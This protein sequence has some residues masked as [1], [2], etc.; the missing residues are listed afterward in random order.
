MQVTGDGPRWCNFPSFLP[1][2]SAITNAKDKLMTHAGSTSQGQAVVQLPRCPRTCNCLAVARCKVSRSCD[3]L[4]PKTCEHRYLNNW[5]KR[6]SGRT[7]WSRLQQRH[8][9][10]NKERGAGDRRE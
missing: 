10:T 5:N 2:Q 1:T 9:Q 3:T 6:L 7:T 4:L 8:V